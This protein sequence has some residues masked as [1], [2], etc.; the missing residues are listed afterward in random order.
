MSVLDVPLFSA[1]AG[2]AIVNIS[3]FDGQNLAN[4]AWAW[5]TLS[6]VN[7]PLL[8]AISARALTLIAEFHS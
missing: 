6:I 8:N 3:L 1:I 2:S 4:T 5:A 7:E